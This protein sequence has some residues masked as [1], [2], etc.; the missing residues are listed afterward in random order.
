MSALT[1]PSGSEDKLRLLV[2][3]HWSALKDIPSLD[4]ARYVTAP[5]R[6][7]V[8]VEFTA[9]QIW[10]AIEDRR[11]EPPTPGATDDEDL[12]VAEWER[13]TQS[14][15]PPPTKEFLVTRVPAV[16][17]FGEFFEETVLVNAF[18][19]SSVA[20]CFRHQSKETRRRGACRR[21]ART[22]LS[23]S[24]TWLRSRREA[25]SRLGESA[26]QRWENR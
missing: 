2:E 26:L 15:P 4:V 13:L 18:V 16:K 22:P 12:K 25:C 6:M 10:D 17:G 14:P 8:L 1:V 3:E 23:Q 19:R 21:R 20:S 9:E 5:S 7:H 11:N 24:P